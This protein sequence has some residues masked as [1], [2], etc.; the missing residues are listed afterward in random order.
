MKVLIFV[1]IL[2]LILFLI[3]YLSYNNPEDW[4]EPYDENVK[5]VSS[6][7][8][9][10]DKWSGYRIGDVYLQDINSPHYN[11]NY[12]DNI[13]YHKIKYP[14]SI[15]SEYITRNNGTTR[16]SKLLNQIIEEKL[17]FHKE[18]DL[19]PSDF[20][21][22]IRS[23]DVFCKYGNEEKY[24]TYSKV[25]NTTWWNNL[26]NYLKKNNIKRVYILSG[27]HTPDCLDI[28]AKYLENRRKF[29][30]KQSGVQV[31][32]KLGEN[33]DEDI[34]FC[35]KAKHFTSTGGGYGFLIGGIVK[36]SGGNFIIPTENWWK[37]YYT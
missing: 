16:N 8:Y 2:I 13:L 34:I 36:D 22:H 29:L 26:V 12:K 21:L 4:F 14:G 15:A 27:T 18:I 3:Y 33:P 10:G 6:K 1:V 37:S 23:G 31:I 35:S 25:Y 20:V 11:I 28:S 17:K 9:N 5:E 19:L 24:I 32:Y 30:Q 7:L